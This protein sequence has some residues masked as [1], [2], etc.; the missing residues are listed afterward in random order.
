MSD[1]NQQQ[2]AKQAG[3]FQCFGPDSF[4]IIIHY[5]TANRGE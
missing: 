4:I 5:L 1:D 2:P 3:I